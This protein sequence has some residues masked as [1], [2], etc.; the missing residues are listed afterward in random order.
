MTCSSLLSHHEFVLFTFQTS[1]LYYIEK[2]NMILLSTDSG[3]V[4]LQLSGKHVLPVANT[5]RTK[6]RQLFSGKRKQ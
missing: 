5:E 1:G 4:N 6:G 2:E 3:I